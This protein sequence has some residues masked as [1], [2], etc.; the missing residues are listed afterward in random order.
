MDERHQDDDV[1]VALSQ[2]PVAAVLVG[3]DGRVERVNDEAAALLGER[4]D[5]ALGV[6]ASEGI[7]L[8]LGLSGQES[9][10]EATASHELVAVVSH[11]L[12]A[13]LTGVMGLL[14]TVMEYWD[15]FDDAERQRLLQMA[16]ENA[17]RMGR[18]LGELLDLSRLEAGQLSVSRESVDVV[19]L[20]DRVVEQVIHAWTDG[21]GEK[22]D[23]RVDLD[24]IP[25]LAAD[26]ERLG[27]VF[28][29]LIENALR[30][31]APPVTVTAELEA[32]QV[33]F[34]VSDSGDGI[35]EADLHRIFDKFVRR[36]AERR[37]GTGLGLH[38]VRGLV[39]AHGGRVWATSTLGQGSQFHVQLPLP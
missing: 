29:N 16:M 22:P 12:R 3:T 14:A 13:P 1:V 34:L 30:Y 32:D 27:Q 19:P 8:V 39:E 31:A 35:A 37:S 24:V 23:I 28:T 33:T 26:E 11:E 2:I 5:D 36:D 7:S 9:H 10:H 6:A 38:I 18:L 25:S 4:V 15:R 21:G 20:I 17:E